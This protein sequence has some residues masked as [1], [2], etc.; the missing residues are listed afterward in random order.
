MDKK[1][2]KLQKILL[3]C[4]VTNKRELLFEIPKYIDSNNFCSISQIIYNN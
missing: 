3:G 2:N 1:I 4:F